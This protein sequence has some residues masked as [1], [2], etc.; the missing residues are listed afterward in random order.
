MRFSL[1]MIDMFRLLSHVLYGAL[2]P[3]ATFSTK[4]R[5][6]INMN[7]MLV[8]PDAI[9]T[10]VGAVAGT[11]TVT[12]FV[13]VVGGCA[14]GKNGP[15]VLLLQFAFLPYIPQP[16]CSACSELRYGCRAYL[17]GRA[18]DS[19]VDDIDWKSPALH[20]AFLTIAVM[21]SVTPYP[22]V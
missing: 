5:Q 18:Y 8:F 4:R 10:C 19:S 7:K 2:P 14:G 17:C 1:C 6:S 12:T 11:S 13:D 16:H 3:R 15:S 20:R 21:A 22:R 9:A